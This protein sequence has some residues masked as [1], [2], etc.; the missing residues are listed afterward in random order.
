MQRKQ[1]ITTKNREKTMR[2]SKSKGNEFF[3]QQAFK[4][5]MHNRYIKGNVWVKDKG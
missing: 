5:N 2:G 1:R 3:H 4:N